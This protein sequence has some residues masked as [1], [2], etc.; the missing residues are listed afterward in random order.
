MEGF[1]LMRINT[2]IDRYH[3]FREDVS[4]I[5]GNTK[6]IDMKWYTFLITLALL[7]I[8][9]G[10]DGDTPPW[11]DP[12]RDYP[13][14]W[15]QNFGTVTMKVDGRQVVMRAYDQANFINDR[16]NVKIEATNCEDYFVLR[17]DLVRE[18]GT[19]D[20]I[21]GMLYTERIGSE[22]FEPGT[23]PGYFF[24]YQHTITGT[25]NITDLGNRIKGTF[26]FTTEPVHNDEHYVITDGS[27]DI[28]VDLDSD[29]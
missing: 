3:S 15:R 12:D 4:L 21:G 1:L 24:G 25:Y 17:L 19:N 6:W 23:G 22:C 9:C 26:E 13:A 7:F 10:G 29:G 20:I 14:Y 8:Q 11:D 27:F 28:E 5:L 18:I 16:Q 2:P